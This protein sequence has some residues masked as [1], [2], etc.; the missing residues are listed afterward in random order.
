MLNNLLD[1]LIQNQPRP[2]T[3]PGASFA[4]DGLLDDL[5]EK[6]VTASAQSPAIEVTPGASASQPPKAVSGFQLPLVADPFGINKVVDPEV[7][8]L[9]RRY[10]APAEPPGFFGRMG[11]SFGAGIEQGKTAASAISLTAQ[12]DMTKKTAQRLA[13]LEAAGKGE[14][15]EAAGLRTTLN[16]YQQRQGRM[17]GDLAARQATMANQPVY[18]GVRALGE[19][20]SFSAA[21]DVLKQDPLNIIA[22]LGAQSLPTMLPG[23]AVGLVNP[24]AGAVTMGLSGAGVELGS[25]LLQYAQE[26]GVNT[27]D[28][29]SLRQFYADPAKLDAAK[30]F[31]ATRA[32]IIGV[33]DAASAG[34]ASKTLVPKAVVNPIARS[35]TNTA[36]QI[37]VQ[38]AAGAGGEAGAQLAT[39]GRITG[40]GEIVAE[41]AGGLF[42]APLEVASMATG[43][44]RA[45]R[46]T[47]PAPVEPPAV[48]P[49]QR[50][51]PT[52]DGLLDDLIRTKAATAEAQPAGTVET[53]QPGSDPALAQTEI[54]TD[55]QRVSTVTG[56]QVDTRL[57]VVDASELRAASGELQPRD[58]TRASSDEQINTIASQ[59]DPQRLSASAEADRG[60][61]IVGPDLIVESGN[62][63]V[64]AIRRAYEM[65]PE[66]S[67]AYRD[68][69]T[70]LGF[71]TAG[72]NQ[73]VLVRE[74]VTPLSDL[75]RKAFVQE[76]NQSSTMALSPVEV[77]QIDV[78]ALQDSVVDVWMGG[79]VRDAANRDF[80][81]A[82]VG[83]LPQAQRNG[84][85]DKDGGLSPDG[86]TRIR[87]ALLAAAY[88]DRDLL[89]KLV[90]SSDDNLKSIGNSLFDSSGQWL[91]MRRMA[92]D[93]IIDPAYDVTAQ[94]VQAARIVDQLRQSRGRI[95]DW[96]AQTD[97][98]GE[99]DPVVDE[100]VRAFYNAN[101]TRAVGRDSIND[102]LRAYVAMAKSQDTAGLFGD[103]PP[104]PNEMVKGAVTQRND[105]NKEPENAALF[106]TQDATDPVNRKPQSDDAFGQ[107]V[108][109]GGRQAEPSDVQGSRTQA[110]RRSAEVEVLDAQDRGS[111]AGQARQGT[112]NQTERGDVNARTKLS[113][114]RNAGADA[115]DR[116]DVY[117]NTV[118]EENQTV[119]GAG[120]DQFRAASFTNRQSNARD[121]Y[122]ALGIDPQDAELLAPV[123]KFALLSKAVKEKYG[124][125]AVI[126]SDKANIQFSIDQ[127]LDAFRNLQFMA[128]VLG[129]PEKSIGLNGTL[130]LGM[131]SQ[132]KFL[133]VYWPKG[134]DP[135]RMEGIATGDATIGLPGRSNSFAHEWGHALDYHILDKY[136]DMSDAMSAYVR[137]GEELSDKFPSSV[138]DSFRLLM[139]AMFF[140][141][142]EMSARIMDLERRIEAAAIKGIEAKGLK[143]ELARLQ[144]GASQSQKG[145]SEFFKTSRD[146]SNDDYWIKPTEMLARSFEAYV[147]HKVEAAGG[148]TEFLAKGDFAYADGADDRLAQTFPRHSDRFNIFRAYD[149]LFEAISIE[150]MLGE[151]QAADNPKAPG[152]TDASVFFE[153]RSQSA[154]QS[155]AKR[156]IALERRV[157][158]ANAVR[159]QRLAE[160]PTTN[161]NLLK[162][163]NNVSNTL[164]Q[165]ER[166]ALLGMEAWYR[167]AGN[168][169]AADAIW[170]ITK[171][172][173]D[174]PGSGREGIK[175]GYFAQASRQ[176]GS[177]WANRLGVMAKNNG[178]DLMSAD[179]LQQ[180]TQAMTNYKDTLASLPPAVKTAA[181]QLSSLT[182]DFYYYMVNAGLDVGFVKDQGFLPRMLDAPLVNADME[183]FRAQAA[184]VYQIV[185]ENEVQRPSDSEDIAEVI[186]SLK[187]KAK[188]ALVQNAPELSAFNEAVAE[189]SKLNKA[190]S[191]AAKSQDNDAIDAAQ[192]N[193]DE[194]L[195]ANMDIF[196][197]AYDFI[198]DAWANTSAI[199]YRQRILFG[200]FDELAGKTLNPG[201]MK[202]RVLPKEAD[203]LLADFYIQNPVER[204]SRYMEQGVRKAEFNRLF[205]RDHRADEEATQYK[206]L[207]DALAQAGVQ[208]HDSELID[209]VVKQ[210]T[211][212]EGSVLPS[213]STAGVMGANTIITMTM[214]SRALLTSFVEPMN[215]GVQT[216]NA[217]DAVRALAL[218]F[219]EIA[220]GKS[221]QDRRLLAKALGIVAHDA[222]DEVIS[223]RLGGTYGETPNMQRRSASWYRKIGMTGYTNAS[224]RSSMVLVSRYVLKMAND[225]VS[226]EAT[227][228]E[229]QWAKTELVDAGLT[230]EDID[231]F[232]DWSQQF[233]GRDPGVNDVV[234]ERGNLTQMGRIYSTLVGRLVDQSVQ[235]PSAVDRPYYL[236]TTMGKITG[237][238]LSFSFAYQRNVLIKSAKRLSRTLDQQ[239]AT[240]AT[241]LALLKL[242][243]TFVAL[244]AS[245]LLVTI[246]REAMLG[247]DKWE[248][249]EKKGTL[250]SWLMQLA[251]D[252]S[253][254]YGA[255]NPIINTI[256]AV[257]YQKDAVG[258]MAGAGPAYVFSNFDRL[259]KYFNQ[260]SENTN[261]GERQAVKALYELSML[262]LVYGVAGLGAGP[263]VGYG[264]GASMA[265][266]T[267]P[268]QKDFFMDVVAGKAEGKQKKAGASKQESPM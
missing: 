260:N 116:S 254:F 233:A 37:P 27:R 187:D 237:G 199:A 213:M 79:D 95:Q 122:E 16:F 211:G 113:T 9:A 252:R 58:R 188:E 55:T 242:L 245:Q 183:K 208:P 20:E 134:T 54:A 120:R 38:A 69:L 1:D 240:D 28:P 136:Q 34:L 185:F 149:L 248:E 78:S 227:A 202:E 162:N 17:T 173:G 59:L 25:S 56:R 244:Y 11:Q 239:G 209:R 50:V 145:R 140:D 36:V 194:W 228:K 204:L 168:K 83:Q 132:S 210:I 156:A 62:G 30:T 112:R 45:G 80:V 226:G 197:S 75:D 48:P 98:T 147:A 100:F 241:K 46:E 192:A 26:N 115:A 171:R 130:N 114:Q 255:F 97:L 159:H 190:L 179:E 91:Q 12:D 43:A 76:A 39:D 219:R 178:V 106:D 44:A 2:A 191:A 117:A 257:R 268:A 24:A 165:S 193:L 220:G 265:Y 243:P 212:M 86:S 267:S 224:R 49:A 175:G 101:L 131:I 124:L 153:D 102:V 144:S 10:P 160:R 88:G 89:T 4:L 119:K 128:S 253:G 230:S 29:E 217:A 143:A 249:E 47:P 14:S 66:Q 77:A 262:P 146:F 218:T 203:S 68:Y 84:I 71:D 110:D 258:L 206:Q 41:G 104:A 118:R 157:L 214:L 256:N 13:A 263:L 61:P 167:Q 129:L 18:P 198:R 205:G 126:K 246:A 251:F 21:W 234:D 148:S 15:P 196:E 166:G 8:S 23:L 64:Q 200:S 161:E 150:Q 169:A 195:D 259:I 67:Q 105:R 201:L 223:E 127:L 163:F 121:A 52:T 22:N 35:V 109:P 180:L 138:K 19:A 85:L 222:A 154:S 181:A 261:S 5:I 151:G 3:K 57:R 125:K 238:L 207:F 137:K 108:Q 6:G 172:I 184:K 81:R 107:S 42:T 31:A 72:I 141:N 99:R 92:R 53:T 176:Q 229:K 96:L 221:V 33:V 103:A 264:L 51:E 142:A 7:Q 32:G 82:F 235:A 232:A 70:S 186:A 40:P 250:E 236:N 182:R 135:A 170:N 231:A 133:G 93:G 266:I 111:A 87:R 158:A 174:D 60:A 189:L 139:N 94:L 90:E 73:P 74:R 216:G 65:F 123:R 215:T 177:H 247:G 63:R 155:W 225:L 164:V 152:M